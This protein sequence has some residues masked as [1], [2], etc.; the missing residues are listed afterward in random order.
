[1]P[2]AECRET[3]NVLLV[4]PDLNLPAAAD[5]VRAVAGALRPAP[6]VGH[7]TRRDVLQALNGHTWD[8]L[9]FATHGSEAGLELSDG[10]ITTSDL[11]AV[12]RASGARLV[13]LNTCSS[14]L[15]GLELHYELSAAVITT[16][17]DVA[18]VTAYQ[19]AALLAQA[20][21]DGLGIVEAY[22][23]SK[24]GGQG[25]SYWLFHDPGCD[26]TAETK[27][28]LLLNEWGSRLGSKIDGLERRLD[29]EIGALRRDLS[30]MSFDV[31]Q[32]VQLPPWHRTA[33]VAAFG[34]LFLPVPLFYS[35]VREALEIGWQAAL[36]LASGAYLF[37]AVLWSYM[38]WGGRKP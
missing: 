20:L 23:A 3:M 2:N 19:T 5:E 34:L 7:V 38:W 26:E 18:D 31:R 1:M 8:I 29:T 11:T 25:Q 4:A 33:F 12:V 13:V 15:I 22:N 6:L 9:W 32:A 10:P 24:P 37:S 30:R 28:I 21:A 14:R 35:Q 27:T 16:V 36:T 17:A